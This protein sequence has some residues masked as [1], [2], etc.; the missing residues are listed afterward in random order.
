MIVKVPARPTVCNIC[1]GPVEL[2]S[3]ATIYGR[4]Y[5]SGK[6]YLCRHCGA[7]VGTHKSGDGTHALGLLADEKMR[8]LKVSCHAIF[9]TFWTT[10]VERSNRYKLLA[11]Q[12][13]IPAK[14][15]H[16][17]YFDEAMLN[18]ALAVLLTW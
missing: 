16:F 1:D 15:C 2:V 11:A 6:A 3:T 4:L 18:K 9:D 13:K 5:G 10:P 7:Y 8:Q 14:A 12:L 17:G